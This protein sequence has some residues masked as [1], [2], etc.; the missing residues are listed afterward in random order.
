MWYGRPIRMR[1]ISFFFVSFVAFTAISVWAAGPQ[2]ADSVSAQKAA[3]GC[4]AGLDHAREAFSKSIRN[5]IVSGRAGEAI[6]LLHEELA[7]YPDDLDLWNRLTQAY[8]RQENAHAAM[9]S[10]DATLKRDPNNERAR[11][12]RLE[13]LM[14]L[15]MHKVALPFIDAE[16]EL[17][18]D[19]RVYRGMRTRASLA[20]GRYQEAIAAADAELKVSPDNPYALEMKARA[21]TALDRF[22]EALATADRMLELNPEDRRAIEYRN[23][24]RGELSRR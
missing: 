7:I 13:V 18:P 22:E 14:L 11:G 24:A 9:Q 2:G 5:L 19:D 23:Q 20:L 12:F 3:S 17:H 10:V 8:I 1:S 6:V 4:G 15:R 21:L 16:L